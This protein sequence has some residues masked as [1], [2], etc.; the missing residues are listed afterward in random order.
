[1]VTQPPFLPPPGAPHPAPHGPGWSPGTGRFPGLIPLRPLTVGEILVLAAQVVR[2]HAVPL[3]L[4]A[5]GFGAVS[6]GALLGLLGATGHLDSYASAAWFQDV[7]DGRTATP[8]LSILAASVVSLLVSA[9]GAVFVSGVAGACAG[10]EAMG[11]TGR[12]AAAERL[13]GRWSALTLVSVVVGAAIAVGLMLLVVPGV[14]AYLALS[15]AGAAVVMER[16]APGEAFRRSVTVVRGHRGRLLGASAAAL[17]G[18]VVLDTVVSSLVLSIFSITDPTTSIVV[19]QG[20]GVVVGAATG[21]WFAAVVALSYIDA[22]IRSEG[23]G[24][25]LQRAAARG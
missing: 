23:L 21:A 15:F 19:Q 18:G 11:R 8:P 17:L 4:L 10:A 14:L 2:R 20:V 9:V 6:A 25:A 7:L 16:V 3:L 13:A 22:R 1:M 24:D 12:A 5:A